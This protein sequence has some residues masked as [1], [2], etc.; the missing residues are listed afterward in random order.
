MNIQKK[1]ERILGLT[2]LFGLFAGFLRVQMLTKSLDE[3]GLL[4]SGSLYS[5]LLWVVCIGFLIF[6]F[7]VSH[8]LKGDGAYRQIFPVCKL[9]GALGIAAGAVLAV[10]SLRQLVQTQWLVGLFGLAAAAAM[11]FTG[12][13]RIRD[14]HPSPLFHC[15]V[16]VFFII[17]LVLSF[18]GW[19]ADPQFQD[20]CIQ[21][22]A[23]VCLMLFSFHRASCDVDLPNRRRTAFFGLSASFFCLA[24]LTD[25]SSLLLYLA[26]GL[27]SV[28]AGC[29]LEPLPRKPEAEE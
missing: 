13:C 17:R 5:I 1:N 4:I 26:G 14:K 24:S 27:W 2:A 15:L 25:S 20:Y 8:P 23:C 12:L 7:A 6:A 11:V 22:M 19:S 28:G 18:R 16:C 9:R 21:M 10:E 29:T 3:K